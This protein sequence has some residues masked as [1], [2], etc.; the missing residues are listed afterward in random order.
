MPGEARDGP[1]MRRTA[2]SPAHPQR[3]RAPRHAAGTPVSVLPRA[4]APTVAEEAGRL[5]VVLAPAEL[6]IATAA[7]FG[8]DIAAAYDAGAG[9]VAADLGGTTFCDSSGLKVLV[10]TALHAKANGLQFEIRNP[11]RLLCR[12]AAILGASELLG[13]PST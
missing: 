6:D 13:I 4:G 11:S 5:A 10:N 2:A 8:R 3:Q 7:A 1:T 9:T 12:M